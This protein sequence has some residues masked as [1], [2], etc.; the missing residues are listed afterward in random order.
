MLVEMEDW[1]VGL[2]VELLRKNR[3]RMRFGSLHLVQGALAPSG[4]DPIEFLIF[5]RCREAVLRYRYELF[6]L[7]C[8]LCFVAVVFCA[9]LAR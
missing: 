9:V 8:L 4:T 7:N 3:P 1:K 5:T 2:E 6:A